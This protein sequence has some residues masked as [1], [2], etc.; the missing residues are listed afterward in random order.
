MQ[1]QRQFRRIVH[2]SLVCV[3][4][5]ATSVQV[6]TQ[7]P[8]RPPQPKPTTQPQSDKSKK[9]DRRQDA[10]ADDRQEPGAEVIRIDTEL[11]QLDV[12]VVDQK[13]NPIF[14][15][16]QNDFTVYEDKVKQAINSVSSE[17][18]PL[19]FGIVVDTSGSM[20][21]K[22]KTVSDAARDLIRL[23]RSDD[24]CFLS[25]FKAEAE[26]VQEFTADKRELEESIEELFTSGGTALLDAI[27]ATSDYAQ[28]KGQRRRKA[29]VV[30]SDG[31]DK[32]SAVKERE[33]ISAIKENEVQLYMIGFIDEDESRS[34]FGKSASKKAQELLIRLADDSGGR[35]FFPKD[36]SE[37]P[38]V[39]A[40]IAKDMRT[41]YVI[42]YYPSN[43]LRDGT[44]RSVRVE[45]NSNNKRKL[46]ARTRQG[47]YARNEQGVIR[48]K[49]RIR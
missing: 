22:L 44:F 47:Y 4:V 33:V 14:G 35:A 37:I 25:Q 42:S 34:F 13:N 19:S 24:E 1:V 3:M 49:G 31:L 21:P 18:V 27:I 43:S 29:I 39:A 40:Q 8:P 15:L 48:E 46:I 16:N 36:L 7:D 45:I 23:M 2:L 41:Q 12:S 10:Q 20:R 9:P 38:A 17:E 32:N 11:V 6:A 26:L 30:I 5:V 28:E